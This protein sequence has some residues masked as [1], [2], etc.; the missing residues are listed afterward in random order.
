MDKEQAGG[1]SVPVSLCSLQ[2][3]KRSGNQWQHLTGS[4]WRTAELRGT[5]CPGG[6]PGPERGL[7]PS[8]VGQPAQK[9]L[10]ALPGLR[11]REAEGYAALLGSSACPDSTPFY[12]PARYKSPLTSIFLISAI[13]RKGIKKDKKASNLSQTTSQ[14][15]RKIMSS[16]MSSNRDCSHG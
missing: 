15:L 11:A 9:L 1:Q 13:N 12:S 10:K 2:C 5:V 3:H 14:V 6:V 4:R 16:N 8:N 7:F